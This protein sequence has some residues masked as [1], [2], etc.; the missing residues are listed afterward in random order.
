[1]FRL[2]D[3]VAAVA[4]IS[5]GTGCATFCDE[6]DDFPVPGRYAAIPGSYT[7]PPLEGEP[8]APAYGTAP[9]SPTATRESGTT[10]APASRD[11]SSGSGSAIDGGDS[12]SPPPPP[13]A[14]AG[15]TPFTP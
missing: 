7:G 3:A 1:M 10:P 6:C 14:G 2:R 4:L 15:T 13:P 11:D 8:R 12:V 9:L 5:C